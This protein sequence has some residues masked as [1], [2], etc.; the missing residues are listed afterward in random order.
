MPSASVL[1]PPFLLVAAALLAWTLGRPGVERTSLVVAAAAWLALGALLGVWFGSGRV[2]LEFSLPGSLGGA[3]LTLRLDAVAVAFG[4]VVLL[5]TALLFSFQDRSGREAAVGALAAAA[6]LLAAEAGSVLLTAVALSGCASLV[7]VA[8]HL[9]EAERSTSGYWLSLSLAALLLLWAGTVLE[10]TGGTSVYSAAPI[11]ALSVPVFVLLAAAG[12]LC[13]G[14]LPARTWVSEVWERDRLEAGALAVVLLTPVGFLLL[15]RAY[16]LGAGQWPN[17]ALNLA[18]AA[19]G[20]VTALAAGLRAQAAANRRA[21]LAEAI[22]LNG[23]IALLALALGS[24]FG[25]SA[26]VLTVAGGALIAALIPLLPAARPAAMLGLALTVGVPPALVF[27][28]RLLALQAAIEAGAPDSFLALAGAG[29]WL[30]AVA[31]VARMPGLP[32]YGEA[33]GHRLGGLLALG[34]CLLGGVGL[35]ALATTLAVPV[36]GATIGSPTATVSGGYF[37]VQTASGG[38]AALTL[39]GPL[40]L[41]ALGAAFW[42]RR[43]WSRWPTPAVGSEGAPPPLVELPFGQLGAW[44]RGRRTRFRVPG[45]YRTLLS[46]AAL[47]RAASSG[48]PWFWGAATLVLIVAVT[49]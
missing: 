15:T 35:G 2:A 9:E 42:S 1:A 17:P 43:A 48:R 4:T 34:L 22:P 41:L 16:V 27:G 31:G 49:R 8:L 14:L 13:S 24:P 26:A 20:A 19:V 38:W 3:P 46:P 11:T 44:F 30:L 18:L 32:A 23:G 40:L 6:S 28:G 36:A 47:E 33:L 39:G 21:Y 29:A 25:V 12:L 7:L 10:V 45:D 5:P 37:G